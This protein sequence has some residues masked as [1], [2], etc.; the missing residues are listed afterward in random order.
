MCTHTFQGKAA[1]ESTQ[2]EGAGGWDTCKERKHPP[3]TRPTRMRGTVD[4]KIREVNTSGRTA[5]GSR[6]TMIGRNRMKRNAAW[7]VVTKPVPGTPNMRELTRE[8]PTYRSGLASMTHG[9]RHARLRIQPHRG[10]AKRLRRWH[11][12]GSRIRQHGTL[13]AGESGPDSAEAG[14]KPLTRRKRQRL[15][16]P[17]RMR[18]TSAFPHK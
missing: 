8:Q 5:L 2:K 16:P 13:A 14:C 6:R 18:A 10:M 12:R 1:G 3:V 7:A 4:S 11:E 15:D 17:W 9:T